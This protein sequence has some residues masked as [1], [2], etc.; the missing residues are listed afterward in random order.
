MLT[1]KEINYVRYSCKITTKI[2]NSCIKNFN[3]K[4]EM[5]I[6]NYLKEQTK[7]YNCKMAFPP[8]IAT[9]KNAAEIHH[10][11]NKT[12]LK[13]G[14]LVI[15]FGVKYKKFCSDQTRTIY[16]RKPSKKEID[17]Y[18][19]VLTSQLES[20]KNIKLG[21]NYSDL[22]NIARSILGNYKKNF[23]HSLGHGLGK[24]IHQSPKISFFSK[25]KI[26]L[27]HVITIEPGL[28]F[29][30]KLGIRIE[31]TILIKKNKIEILTK[32][33]KNNLI[34]KNLD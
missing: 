32:T 21:M 22:D 10:T 4:T 26:K 27:N 31:D 24:K 15:D 13:K 16:L 34:I 6:L 30:N 17:L 23:I 19:L 29:K 28:Y 18:Y 33:P 2:I 7:K 3:F 25:D 20:I 11:P 5:D 8:V 12:K 1:K 14:F 9:A